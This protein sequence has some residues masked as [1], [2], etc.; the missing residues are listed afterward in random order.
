MINQRKMISVVD[1]RRMTLVEAAIRKKNLEEQ[2]IKKTTSAHQRKMISVVD[3]MK[4]EEL[5]LS[6]NHS[7]T[8]R[9]V[10]QVD[11]I[12]LHLKNQLVE[13][14]VMDLRNLTIQR[15][16]NRFYEELARF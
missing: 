15:K 11:G 4:S 2:V 10:V 13:G 7:V 1:I 8:R 6:N 9:L 16:S 5:K 3:G 12:N 14:L